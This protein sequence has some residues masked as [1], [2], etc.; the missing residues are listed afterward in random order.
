MSAR[1]IDAYAFGTAGQWRRC[2]A[3]GFVPRGS[4]LAV[5]A[6][7]GGAPRP[8][9]GSGPATGLAVDR[10]G[11][12]VWRVRAEGGAALAWDDSCC[13]RRGPFPLDAL[14]A[15]SPR[16]LLDAHRLTAFAA[17]RV[18][19]LDRASLQPEETILASA[20]GGDPAA[21]IL[22]VAPDGHGGL[23]LLLGG[24]AGARLVPVPCRGCA[25][26]GLPLPC[27]IVAATQLALAEGGRAL[28]VLAPEDRR[29]HLLDTSGRLLRSR[30]LGALGPGFAAER[31]AGDGRLLALSGWIDAPDGRAWVLTPLDGSGEPSGQPRPGLPGTR[32]HDFALGDG[33]IWLATDAGVWQIGGGSGEGSPARAVL[34]TPLLHSP[35]GGDTEGW[36]R[37]EID[38]DLPD[39]AA[40][41]VEVGSTDD[42]RLAE[43]IRRVEADDSRSRA[44]R[45]A[46]IWSLVECDGPGRR[47]L[48]EGWR[49]AASGRL[50]IPLFATA[51]RWLALRLTIDLPPLA[52]PPDLRAMRILYPGETLM[53]D[54]PAIFSVPEGDPEGLLRRLVGVLETTFQD[55]DAGIARI[56]DLLDA[57]TTPT[58]WLDYLGSWFGLPWHPALAEASKRALLGQ[59]GDLL[60]ERG[61]LPGLVRLLHC[62]AGAGARVTVTDVMAERRPVRLGGGG[63]A[64]TPAR[65]LLAGR[66]RTAATLGR[67]AV[68]GRSRLDCADM[69]P[70]PLDVLA[71]F[72]MIEIAGDPRLRAINADSLDAILA[73]YLPLGVSHRLRWTDGPAS[74]DGIVLDGAG[75]ARLGETSRIGRTVLDGRA[76]GAIGPEIGMAFRLR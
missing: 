69:R 6:P 31:I 4:G 58:A 62:L 73:Q 49:T 59:A 21:A 23:W 17:D 19:R 56:G 5:A 9:P 10:I 55:L 60:D 74:D 45:L 50:A 47:F 51:D 52:A 1:A 22:D 76:R 42:P 14:V 16:L 13:G 7:P 41:A 57:G 39:G 67:K 32:H 40:L 48:V 29:L 15:A 34:L 46:E 12:L 65:G 2:L 27:E 61:T 66:P 30:W 35:P 8:V 3:T 70:G 75:P 37:A 24:P 53:R 11:G 33:R 63:R 20:A 38:L 68:L 18:V 64:G 25:G 26:R 54:L 36:L 44:E 72:L 28:A 43:R 71:P